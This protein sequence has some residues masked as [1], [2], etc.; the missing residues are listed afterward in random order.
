MVAVRDVC[1]MC[2][3]TVRGEG[4]EETRQWYMHVPAGVY[5]YKPEGATDN[6]HLKYAGAVIF[7]GL[8]ARGLRDLGGI[9][10]DLLLDEI[11]DRV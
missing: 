3:E 6:T 9:Y 10:R 11:P 8:I 1:G 5:P 4:D 2:W 7:A